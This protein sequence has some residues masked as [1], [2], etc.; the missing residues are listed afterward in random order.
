MKREAS[1]P[2]RAPCNMSQRII[3]HLR[4]IL[5]RPSR[6]LFYLGGILREFGVCL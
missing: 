2:Q 3:L 5:R 6:V 4:C 1:D